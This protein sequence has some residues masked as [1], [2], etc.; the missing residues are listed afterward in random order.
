MGQIRILG[1]FLDVGTFVGLQ[2]YDRGFLGTREKYRGIAEQ[3]PAHWV[4]IFGGIPAFEGETL[5]DYLG[6]VVR[7]VDEI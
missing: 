6:G 5:A 4:Q 1:R 2:I 3:I 7:D